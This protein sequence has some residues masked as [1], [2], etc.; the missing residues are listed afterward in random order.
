MKG[1]D[2]VKK[3]L[4]VVKGQERIKY[5]QIIIAM[6]KEKKEGGVRREKRGEK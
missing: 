1:K 3:Y 5:G 2:S 6:I 4:S